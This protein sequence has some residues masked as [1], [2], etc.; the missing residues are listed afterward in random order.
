MTDVSIALS[1]HDWPAVAYP[2]RPS[3]QQPELRLMFAVLAEAPGIIDAGV[4]FPAR[5]QR[6]AFMEATEWVLSDDVGWPFSFRNLCCAL[7]V[8]VKRLRARIATALTATSGSRE[9]PKLTVR[10]RCRAMRTR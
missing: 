6:A 3:A 2:G 5:R 1:S 9:L 8:N 7:D 10:P 4:R